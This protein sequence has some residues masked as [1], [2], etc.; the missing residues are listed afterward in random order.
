MPFKAQNSPYYKVEIVLPGYGTTPRLSSKTERKAVAER[1]EQALRYVWEDGYY[2]LIE[3]L[4]PEG[5]GQGGRIDL[6]TLFHAWRR[7]K[8]DA[9]AR[10]LDD[11]L[12]R[13][14]VRRFAQTLS[15][16]NHQLGARHLLRMTVEP[17]GPLLAG[18]DARVSW[19]YEPSHIDRCVRHMIERDGYEPN[20]VRNGVWGFLSKFLQD[21][22]GQAD[23]RAILSQANRPD[24]DDRRDVIL[25]P[26]ALHRV[27]C[28]SEWEVRM[29]LLIK[30]STGIDKSP[31]LRIRTRDVDFERWTLFVRD[32][33]TRERRAVIDLPPVATYALHVLLQDRNTDQKAFRLSR[34][35]LDYRWRKARRD[36]GLT[37]ENGY[38]KGVRLKDL[39]HTFAAH[40]VRA[41]GNLAGLMGRLRHKREAQSLMYARYETSG[42]SDMEQAAAAMGLKLP[43]RLRKNLTEPDVEGR[44]KLEIP[45]WWFDPSEP[46]RLMGAGEPEMLD[47]PKR[48]GQGGGRKG[49]VPDDYRQAVN[50]A[51]SISGAARLLDVSKST[52]R[53]QCQRHRIPVPSLDDQVPGETSSK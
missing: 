17:S 8:L 23:T 21:R 22:L 24:T 48:G 10:R 41:G 45:A 13:S 35:Q 36:A 32:N 12:L 29:F 27:I 38:E 19:L 1:M 37:P 51:G 42:I 40:Y 49:L 4:E 5:P 47:V 20:T 7:G 34:G 33:K 14:A 53:G 46:P 2:A 31:I 25:S 11:P 50:Q 16:D 3:A 28:A 39:R 52:V 15:Y 26:A 30:A 44:T 9:L 6:P 18:R 43:D